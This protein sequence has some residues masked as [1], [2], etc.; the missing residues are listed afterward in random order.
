MKSETEKESTVLPCTTDMNSSHTATAQTLLQTFQHLKTTQMSTAYF[1][2]N[3]ILLSINVSS[4]VHLYY[5]ELRAVLLPSLVRRA[6]E[7]KSA[8]KINRRSQ[9]LSPHASRS[10]FSRGAN[11]FFSP[12]FFSLAQGTKLGK[13]GLLVVYLELTKLDPSHVIDL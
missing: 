8:R 3:L 12:I 5:L 11:L 7:K 2:N 10:Q 6:S 13:R 1:S 4:I 9:K